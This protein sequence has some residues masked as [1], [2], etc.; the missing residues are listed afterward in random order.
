MGAALAWANAVNALPSLS[1]MA[2]S[3]SCSWRRPGSSKSPPPSTCWPPCRL[4]QQLAQLRDDLEQVPHQSIVRHF[5]NGRFGVLVDGDDGARVLD[6]GEMLNRTGNTDCDIQL[7]GDDLAGLP[8]LQ[9]VG[10]EP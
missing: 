3:A 4:L 5:E 1:R 9:L 8:H 6:A 10:R 2:L 7:R